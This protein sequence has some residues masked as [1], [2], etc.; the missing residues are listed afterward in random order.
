MIS[1]QVSQ[2][3]SREMDQEFRSLD[4][5]SYLQ[6]RIIVWKVP[7][8]IRAPYMAYAGKIIRIPFVLAVREN[9]E[10]NDKVLMPLIE[11]MME[12]AN[13]V[14]GLSGKA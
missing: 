9:I 11:K 8:F 6:R 4:P 1:M 7:D 10:D 2:D 3:L 14:Y 12:E 5:H 13:Q